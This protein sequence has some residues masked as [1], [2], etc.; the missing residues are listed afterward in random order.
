MMTLPELAAAALEQFLSSYMRRRFGSSQTQLSE[1]LPAAARIALECIGNSDALYH[2]VEHTLLVTLAGH[3]ILRGR[4]L[5]SHM[6]AD[7]YVH[8]IMACLLHDIGYVRGLFREDDADGFVVDPAGRKICLPRGSSD[9]SLMSYHVDRSKLYVINRIEGMAPL[10][11]DRIARAIE[12]TRFPPLA[13]QQFDEEQSIVRA[14]DLI[15]QL[16]DPNYI[17]KANALYHEFEEVGINRQLGYDSPADI[18]H[19]YPQFYWNS[20]APHIQTEIRYLN[21]TSTGRQ[22]IANLYANVFRAERDISLS[23]PQT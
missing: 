10:D 2:N 13:G 4:A 11:K 20:V 7:D 21:M 6:T 3:E 17:R 23:G 12:G 1:F 16:G 14:A 15:G 8:V 18:V 22:W 19:R 9:A 5:H